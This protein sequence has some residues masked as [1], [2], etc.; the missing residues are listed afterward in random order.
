MSKIR[1]PL[2]GPA[3]ESRSSNA[4]AQR[5]VNCYLEMDSSSPRAP[6]ALYGTPG[7]ILRFTLPTYP[8]RSCITQDT[9]SYWIA[10][11][12]VYRVN[13]SYAYTALG[14]IGT[15]S[16][17][18][19]IASNGQ[20]IL[21]VDG[22]AG[23]LVTTSTGVLS[24]ITDP[25][26]PNGVKR[27][28]YQDGY[29]IVSAKTGSPSFWINTTAYDGAAWDALD[30]ASAEGAPDNTIGI[31]SDHRELWLFGDQ[32]AEVWVN[33]GSTDFPFQR[34]G[35][36]FIEHGCAAGGTVAKADN[37]VFW[38]GADDKGH[39]IVW[40]ANGYTPMRISTHAL[41]FAMGSYTLSDAFAFTYQQE[42]HIFYVLTFPTNGA[43]WVYDAA[44]Q[45]WHERA[46]RNPSTGDLGRW[47][48][49]CSCF[50][51]EHLVGDWE[52]GKVYALDLNTFTDNGDPLIRIR[53]SQTAENLQERIFFASLQID[54]ETGVGLSSGQGSDPQLML[55]WSNDGGHTWSSQKTASIGKIGEYG[56]RALFRRLGQGRN[57][58]WEISLS[59]PV[60]FAV[61]GAVVYI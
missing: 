2:V 11:N 61:I 56:N 60:K 15:S 22:S 48:A 51:G 12:T 37:T 19:G 32:S 43:T 20:Q 7:T 21:I 41:E 9:Y 1:V 31:I 35:N 18:L 24:T 50:F 47:R 14:T 55:R 10:G 3:Y 38:L 45:Q 57:R 59:D 54:M 4:D 6:M 23:Y 28:T 44:T 29:F 36:T 52:T 13:S 34:S 17:E 42:G 58:V 8:V 40:R 53:A 5:A 30:F 39:G 49:N 27:A 25:D 33:T 26:F 46:W 16:G